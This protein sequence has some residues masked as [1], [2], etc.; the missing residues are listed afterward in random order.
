ME[1]PFF[2]KNQMLADL[3]APYICTGTCDRRRQGQLSETKCSRI[4]PQ[5]QTE[6]CQSLG[7]KIKSWK[8]TRANQT[9]KITYQERNNDNDIVKTKQSVAI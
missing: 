4:A 6:C 3:S 2:E 7:M 5:K 8:Q 9:V 1:R